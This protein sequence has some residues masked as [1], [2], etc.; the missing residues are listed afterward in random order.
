MAVRLRLA[1]FGKKHAP[2]FRIVAID[3]RKM[4]DGKYLENLG[5]YNPVT[6]E[7]VQFH[8]DRIDEWL[9][10][11]AV[12][13]DSVKKLYK[14]FKQGSKSK[15]EKIV[16]EELLAEATEVKAEESTKKAKKAQVEAV[17]VKEEVAEPKA[18]KASK[19]LHVEKEEKE[20]K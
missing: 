4:R 8:V 18:E 5:T 6:G 12:P 7:Y 14:K 11:G 17:E 2:V 20:A 15:A 3:S 16:V 19:K 9:K 13:S 1:L 10:K